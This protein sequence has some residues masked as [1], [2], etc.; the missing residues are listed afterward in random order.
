[1]FATA[2]LSRKSTNPLPAGRV[3][4]RYLNE[5]R[6]TGLIAGRTNDWNWARCCLAAIGPETCRSAVAPFSVLA[7]RH[8]RHLNWTFVDSISDTW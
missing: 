5:R 6:L 4:G 1:M 2:S 8:S 3:F 7:M